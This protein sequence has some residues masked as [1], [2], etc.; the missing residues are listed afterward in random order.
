[1]TLIRWPGLPQR[2]VFLIKP[3]P[4]ANLPVQ[5]AQKQAQTLFKPLTQAVDRQDLRQVLPLVNQDLLSLAVPGGLTV[6]VGFA[7]DGFG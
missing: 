5:S 7:P 6:V 3:Q 2:S 1:M 4:Q